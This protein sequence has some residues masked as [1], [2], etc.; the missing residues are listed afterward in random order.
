MAG[1]KKRNRIL[2]VAAGL[3][4]LALLIAGVYELLLPP[5]AAFSERENRM[6]AEKPAFSW[7]AFFDGSFA[8]APADTQIKLRWPGENPSSVQGS[9]GFSLSGTTL[10]S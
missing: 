2:I 9:S 1:K 7:R 4:L 6:L 10:P 3:L 5:G 8:D